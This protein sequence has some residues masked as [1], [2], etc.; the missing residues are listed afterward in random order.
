[1]DGMITRKKGRGKSW[2][3]RGKL[4]RE[5]HAGRKENKEKRE[6][7]R[8]RISLFP[9]LSSDRKKN[10]GKKKKTISFFSRKKDSRRKFTGKGGKILSL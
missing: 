8:V 6:K 7:A 3:I 9:P 5:F 2:G 4:L 1:M 10:G